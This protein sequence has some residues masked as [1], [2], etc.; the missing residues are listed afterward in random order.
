MADT[1]DDYVRSTTARPR[2][3]RAGSATSTS[4]SMPL[5]PTY[6][7]DDDGKLDPLGSTEDQDPNLGEV[8]LDFSMMAPLPHDRQRPGATGSGA[9]DLLGIA[10]GAQYRL[11]VPQEPSYDGHRRRTDGRRAPDA[12]AERHHREPRLRHRR[13]DRLPRPLPGGRPDDPG[14]PGLHREV[15]HRGGRLLQRRHPAG[16]ARSRSDP[17]AAAPPPTRTT[18][19]KAQT[20]IDDVEPTIDALAGGRQRGHRGRRHDHRRHADLAPTRGR[21]CT[22]RPA[23]TAR[24]P[25]PRASA[26]ASTSRR[27]AT[28]C[29]PSIHVCT[30][31]PAPRRTSRWPQRRHLRLGARDRRRRR[32]RAAGREGHPPVR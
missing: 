12:A 19:A 4:P 24:P 31:D 9:T 18:D 7:A 23:T 13:G 22:R 30:S 17:T 32:R 15:R 16:A 20:N 2:S 6:T 8:L 5:I 29:R 14:H 26:P 11:V 3:S 21:A 1:G 28:T 25:T 27:P 10:P